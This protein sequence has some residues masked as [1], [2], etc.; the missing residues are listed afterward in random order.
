MDSTLYIYIYRHKG[1]IGLIYSR[2]CRGRKLQGMIAIR[3]VY[4][5]STNRQ[6]LNRVYDSYLEIEWKANHRCKRVSDRKAEESLFIRIL[7]T[8][9]FTH[10][11]I[12]LST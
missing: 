12:R 11:T 2:K 3:S 4:M 7:Y 8:F 5:C 6:R 9:D 1:L 10:Y